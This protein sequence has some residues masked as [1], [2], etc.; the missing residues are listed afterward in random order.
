[1][2]IAAELE[3]KS[4]DFGD[5]ANE[6]EGTRDRMRRSPGCPI[7]LDSN[8]LFQCLRLNQLDWFAEVGENARVML[9]LR[10]LEEVDAKKYAG[11]QR[12]SDV[13]RSILPWIDGLFP[14]G[15]VGP[16]FLRDRATI[17]LLLADR[18][19]YRPSDADEE[20]LDVTH[21]VGHFV[22]G[23][24]LMTADTGMRARARTEGIDVLAVPD[25]WLRRTDV[26]E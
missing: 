26:P 2:L 25:K 12:L 24:K 10:V 5:V 20:V 8:V 15:D 4:F 1:L 17:E 14:A 16:V 11:N 6:L 7:V 21:E 3:S 23:V 19:R 9:P 22:G 18:P 13:A